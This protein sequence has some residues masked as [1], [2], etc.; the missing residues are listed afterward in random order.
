MSDEVNT[1]PCLALR[2]LSLRFFSRAAMETKNRPQ[3]SCRGDL[4]EAIFGV[5]AETRRLVISSL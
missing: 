4:R 5:M 2:G 3:I 1:E